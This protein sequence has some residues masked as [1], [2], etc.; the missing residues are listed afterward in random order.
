MAQVLRKIA[1]M[2]LTNKAVQSGRAKEHETWKNTLINKERDKLLQEFL[3]AREELK[4]QFDCEK[5]ELVGNYERRLRYLRRLLEDCDENINMLKLNL[6]AEKEENFILKTKIMELERERIQKDVDENLPKFSSHKAGYLNQSYDK[7][8]VTT[9]FPCSRNT[10]TRKSSYQSY[11]STPQRS[12]ID[13]LK[14]SDRFASCGSLGT[15]DSCFTSVSTLS[16]VPSFDEVQ[17]DVHA[18][19]RKEFNRL[20]KE[21]RD[22]QDKYDSQLEIEKERMNEQIQNE[23]LQLER[24]VYRQLNVRL[25]REIKKQ[26]LLLTENTHLRRTISNAIME[27]MQCECRQQK[28]SKSG[29]H[30]KESNSD[31]GADVGDNQS[32]EGSDGSDSGKGSLTRENYFTDSCEDLIKMGLIDKVV[33]SSDNVFLVS[34]SK[35]NANGFLGE[36]RNFKEEHDFNE[37][38]LEEVALFKE[39]LRRKLFELEA[40]LNNDKGEC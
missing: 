28:S 7:D 14:Y 38:C 37:E 36:N 20:L 27:R 9:S 34:P 21:L 25:D 3:L 32:D 12:S 10:S 16:T 30:W 33:E 23:K 19:C 40:L 15:K 17:D 24:I 29:H 18:N 22:K 13:G 4:T 5:R 31:S 2:K 35:D 8:S 11:V 6:D 26:E 1:S 39:D